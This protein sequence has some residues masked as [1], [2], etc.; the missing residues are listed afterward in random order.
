MS[1]PLSYQSLAADAGNIV[2][3]IQKIVDEEV[4]NS[5]TPGASVSVIAEGRILATVSSGFSDVEAAR[6]VTSETVF[7]VASLS[8]L[9]TATLMMRQVEENNIQLDNKANDYLKPEFWIRDV[10]GQPTNATIRQLLSHA[11]G[12]PFPN[13][14]QFDTRADGKAYTLEEFLSQG[15]KSTHAPGQ[16]VIYSNEGYA[17]LGYIAAQ[18]YGKDFEDYAQSALLKPLGM[19]NSSFQIQPHMREN[20]ATLYGELFDDTALATRVDI[21]AVGP[22]ASLHTTADDLARFSLLFL[23]GGVL[24]GERLLSQST[25][26]EM[27]RLQS[28]IHPDQ[29]DGFGL[30]FAVIGDPRRPLVGWSGYVPGAI[31]LQILLPN[32]GIGISILT[33]AANPGILQTISSRIID[34]LLG[35]VKLPEPVVDESLDQLE[36]EY[37]LAEFPPIPVISVEKSDGLLRLGSPFHDGS[38]T[39]Y[40][41]GSGRFWSPDLFGA[42]VLSKNDRLYLHMFE[43]QR[44]SPWGL[45]VRYS[46]TSEFLQWLFWH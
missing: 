13:S 35:P 32:S 10:S 16:T 17:L 36:S 2:D 39:L 45:A 43:L 26:T 31:S 42:T 15:L 30:G 7:P 27:L 9:I 33:N 28:T 19:V 41:L 3:E 25:I 37:R 22:A 24:N 46:P 29:Q 34:L 8:K 40:P 6:K 11:S 23:R 44:V 18:A 20:L 1:M 12:L 38:I 5:S 21:S 14:R 4:T